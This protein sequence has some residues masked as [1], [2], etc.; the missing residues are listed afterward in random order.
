[1]RRDR[2]RTAARPR[3]R[4]RVQ[5]CLDSNAYD[6]DCADG[7]GDGPQYTRFTRVTGSGPFGLDRDHDGLGRE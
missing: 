4:G 7:S 3:L 6:Y 1:M 5:R 2:N